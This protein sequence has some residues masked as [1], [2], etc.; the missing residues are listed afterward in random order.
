MRSRPV[1]PRKRANQD[2]EEAIDHYVREGSRRASLGFIKALE[3]AY[4]HI[5]RHPGAGS[6]RFGHELDIPGLRAWPLGRYPHIV[7]YMERGDHIDVW[8]IL[9]AKRD[10]PTWITEEPETEITPG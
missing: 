10:I 3:K 1:I 9:H 6:R 8:R 7:F 2:V 5:G 4:D